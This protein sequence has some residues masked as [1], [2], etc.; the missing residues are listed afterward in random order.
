MLAANQMRVL[1]D[2]Y[3][4]APFA[5]YGFQSAKMKS[6]VLELSANLHEEISAN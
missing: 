2:D 5:L 3:Y 6:H 1:P 4:K